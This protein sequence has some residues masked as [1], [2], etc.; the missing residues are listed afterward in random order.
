MSII[1]SISSSVTV[2]AGM[3][4]SESARGALSSSPRAIAPLG[5]LRRDVAPEVERQ[6]Q[7]LAAHLAAA[8]PA[9]Q[10]VQAVRQMLARLRH[11]R[12]EAWLA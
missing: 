2:S 5:D 8:M 7:A 12:E 4:R 9:R 1:R 3:K 10:R 11:A 6:Q